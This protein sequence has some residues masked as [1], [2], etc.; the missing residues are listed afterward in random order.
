MKTY[1][2]QTSRVWKPFIA[3]LLLMAICVLPLAATA[4]QSKATFG[5]PAAS[6]TQTPTGGSAGGTVVDISS[7]S[8]GVNFD[9]MLRHGLSGVMLRAANGLTKDSALD[10][11]YEAAASR[12]IPVGVYQYAQWNRQADLFSAAQAAREEAN[13]LIQCLQGK[14]IRGYVA[15]DLEAPYDSMIKLSPSDMTTVANL[16]LSILRTAG[17]KPLLYCNINWISNHLE[18]DRIEAPLWLAY[19]KDSGSDEFPDDA[20]GQIM[21]GLKD[22]IL[23]WQYSARGNQAYWGATTDLNYLYYSFTG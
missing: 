12:N 2:N 22:R 16:Y 19:Y 21:T 5:T 10:S 20:N 17:Y 6:K 8:T 4:T 3:A 11:Y 13:F 7:Y 15:L 18:V 1:F 14:N 23:M 9:V